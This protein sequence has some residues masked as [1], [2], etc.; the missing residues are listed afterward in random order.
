[1]E[2]IYNDGALDI[3]SWCE[4]LDEGTLEQAK[5]VAKHP[6]VK[7]HVALM[8][9]AHLGYGM[10][11][12]GVAC[13][14]GLSPAM[15]GYDIGCGM[16]AMNTQLSLAE[17]EPHLDEIL[18]EIRRTIPTGF[19]THDKGHT[20]P[21]H[22]FDHWMPNIE[23][24]G[25]FNEQVFQKA[26]ESL[27]TL[28]GGNHFIEIQHEKRSE[29][30]DRDNVWV[31][32]HSGS[33]KLGHDIADYYMKKAEEADPVGKELGVP[34]LDYCSNEGT[35]YV[36]S[37]GFALA[38]AQRNRAI[39][40]EM[41]KRIFL[42][43][44]GSEIVFRD[45]VNIHHNYASFEKVEGSHLWVHRK[46]ATSAKD[47]EVGIIPGSMGTSSFIVTGM[48]SPDSFQSC[49]HGA[50]RKRGRNDT[51]RGVSKEEALKSIE[52]VKFA[53]FSTVKRGKLKGELDIGEAPAAYKDINEVIKN[54]EDLVLPLV[55]LWPL[56]VVKG[57]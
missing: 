20:H 16:C 15:V 8:P 33:R 47:F 39:M 19:H 14:D 5:N 23:T 54:Q 29:A 3:W 7:H 45:E 11:I 27:G 42:N 30:F 13:V 28:G 10:P 52:H 40:L 44:F 18:H 36:V 31:M 25:W 12:G 21:W 48:G 22:G 34:V 49:S 32:L 38:Y 51:I 53:G 26:Q 37:M 2:I 43:I 4:D 35:E 41:I 9:D 56:G 24:K 1:M 55:Q 6:A 57:D 17:V 50:G 46:G